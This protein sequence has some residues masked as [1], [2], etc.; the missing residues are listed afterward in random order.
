MVIEHTN[1]KKSPMIFKIKDYTKI[2]K[3]GNA[4]GENMKKAGKK[5][6]IEILEIAFRNLH[7]HNDSKIKEQNFSSNEYSQGGLCLLLELLLRN[8]RPNTETLSKQK[9][10]Y[11]TPEE[12]VIVRIT[13]EKR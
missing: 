4:K 11:L 3:S 8:S 10:M 6:V 12:A 5:R 2:T 9:I 1:E 13:T 7:I